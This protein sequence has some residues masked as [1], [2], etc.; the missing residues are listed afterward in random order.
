MT[1][2]IDRRRA[3]GPRLALTMADIEA[4]FGDYA[5]AL[6]WAAVAEGRLGRLPRHY[7]DRHELWTETLALQP[8][9]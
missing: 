8:A 4:G 6:Y 1:P 9:D 2:D 3:D 5:R 7:H